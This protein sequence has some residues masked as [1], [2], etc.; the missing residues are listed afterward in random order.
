MRPSPDSAAGQV[1]VYETGSDDPAGSQV[2][3]MVN[4]NRLTFGCH[5]P[6]RQYL[7][8]LKDKSLEYVLAESL[9][10]CCMDL[11]NIVGISAMRLRTA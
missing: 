10:F 6:Q 8:A 5:V 9:S 1:Q 11:C 2:C 7:D 4:K 3:F